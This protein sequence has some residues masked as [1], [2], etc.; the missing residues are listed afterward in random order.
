MCLSI[1][2]NH[3]S[4]CWSHHS[5]IHEGFSLFWR[6]TLEFELTLEMKTTAGIHTAGRCVSSASEV[7]YWNFT[8]GRRDMET[9]PDRIC[10][11]RARRRGDD[12]NYGTVFMSTDQ[13]PTWVSMKTGFLFQCGHLLSCTATS[14]SLFLRWHFT[15]NPVRL[16]PRLTSSEIR[17]IQKQV[18]WCL[19]PQS[20]ESKPH[21]KNHNNSLMNSFSLKLMLTL[22][23]PRKRSIC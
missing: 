7:V 13:H 23:W 22:W 6:Q 19:F 1:L 10:W 2:M 16:Q 20:F 18:S 9:S 11:Q 17:I 14:V 21:I 15:S 5:W 4:G 8:A 3:C 12:R